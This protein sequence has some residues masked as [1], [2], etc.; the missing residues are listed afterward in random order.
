M[1][2]GTALINKKKLLKISKI[3]LK[4][5]FY[6]QLL[7][8]ETHKETDNDSVEG[9]IYSQVPF[10]FD[11]QSIHAFMNCKPKTSVPDL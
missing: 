7:E 4:N 11:Q 9:I 6:L 5:L 10:S 1:L 3:M 2:P 8:K